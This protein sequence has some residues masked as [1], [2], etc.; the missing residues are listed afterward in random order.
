MRLAIRAAQAVVLMVSSQTRSS[1]TVKEHLRLADLYQRRLILVCEAALGCCAALLMLNALATHPLVWPLYVVTGL[2]PDIA[3]VAAAGTDS[4]LDQAINYVRQQ[5][6]SATPEG[7]TALRPHDVAM[8]TGVS[9]VVE[10]DA[11]VAILDSGE[12]SAAGQSGLI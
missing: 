10:P 3:V 6:A 8:P 5:S 7:P 1:R 12:R 11:A 9:A 4:V 2:A